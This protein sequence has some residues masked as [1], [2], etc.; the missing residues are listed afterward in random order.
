VFF[1]WFFR[2]V[3][4][5]LGF[6]GL[7]TLSVGGL[8]TANMMFLIVAERTHEIGLRMA[9]G[10]KQAHILWQFVLETLLLVSM[11]GII[12]A[13]VS[14]GILF[15]MRAYGLPEWL[16]IPHISFG[17][18]LSTIFILA[19]VGLVAGFFPARRAANMEPVRALTL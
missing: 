17:T 15:S 10:A 1:T 11:G 3:E 6:C 4:L 7:L 18:A 12:G 19:F 13:L 2:V 14:I 5:F 9:L 16:G 8:G